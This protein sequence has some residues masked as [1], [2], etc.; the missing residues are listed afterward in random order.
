MSDS[1]TASRQPPPIGGR[2]IEDRLGEALY[3]WQHGL[4]RPLWQDMGSA[5]QQRWR[6]EGDIFRQT[7]MHKV[8]LKVEITE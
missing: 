7:V 1:A 4:M 8:G 5:E 6:D 2:S 3:R